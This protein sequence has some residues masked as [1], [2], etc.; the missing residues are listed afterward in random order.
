MAL[1]TRATIKITEGMEQ[2]SATTPTES[3][4][5]VSGLVISVLEEARCASSTDPF[6]K[7]SSL[8]IRLMETVSM[9]KT[10]TFS[11]WSKG[12]CQME[13]MEDVLLILG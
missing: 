1:T 10:T 12:F 13:V 11:K 8:V 2:E 3:S 9:K 7:D 6:I 5:K 4:T